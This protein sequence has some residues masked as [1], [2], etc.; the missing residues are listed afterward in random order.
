M[1]LW[2]EAGK[3]LA[4]KTGAFFWTIAAMV[5]LVI[6]LALLAIGFSTKFP[7]EAGIFSEPGFKRLAWEVG[8]LGFTG[9]IVAVF[10]RMFHSINFLEAA[11]ERIMWSD[12]FL[13]KRNDIDDLWFKL[14]LFKYRRLSSLEDK[15]QA[16]FVGRLTAALQGAVG[17][18]EEQIVRD[19]R[20]SIDIEWMDR[21]KDVIKV[22]EYQTYDVI[23][24][25]TDRFTITT[26]VTTAGSLKVE[27]YN[28]L[29]D[30]IFLLAGDKRQQLELVRKICEDHI[31]T[32]YELSGATLYKLRRERVVSWQLDRDPVLSVTSRHVCDGFSLEVNCNAQSLKTRFR[33]IGARKCFRDDMNDEQKQ[34]RPG[35][36]RQVC[37]DTLLPGNGFS[38]FFQRII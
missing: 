2:S 29:K 15:Q 14:T 21:Q 38:L 13:A 28:V 9:G 17:R 24:R 18:E 10:I 4:R 5:I 25:N 31:E 34:A 1:Q 12:A 3:D 6:C 20:R 16:Q 26:K 7:S 27:E 23:P 33:E 32:T 35:D 37:A 11:L 8:A 30:E 36:Q 19:H 22:R